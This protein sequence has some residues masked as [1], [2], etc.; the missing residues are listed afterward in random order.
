MTSRARSG[1]GAW[2]CLSATLCLAVIV[3]S[4]SD[5]SELGSQV[6]WTWALT[7]LQVMA[8]WVAGRGQA[9]GWMVGSAVQPGWIAAGQPAVHRRARGAEVAGRPTDVAAMG[10]MPVEHRQSAAS[11]ARQV[12]RRL[13]VL[14]EALERPGCGGDR[15]VLATRSH[16]TRR[17][18]HREPPSVL[19]SDTTSVARALSP[20]SAPVRPHSAPSPGVTDVSG[21]DHRPT[22]SV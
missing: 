4:R 7:G 3:S 8:L 5:P 2:L 20:S 15:W 18:R 21:R 12:G 17:L 6:Y 11:V 16:A 22:E 14:P 1:I 10:P 19:M 9:W 13:T